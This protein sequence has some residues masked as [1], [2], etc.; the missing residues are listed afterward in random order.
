MFA[1]SKKNEFKL[2]NL[3][4]YKKSELLRNQSKLQI[5]SNKKEDNI[6]LITGKNESVK[7][8]KETNEVLKC[9][10]EKISS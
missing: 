1:S 4:N 3:N 6:K 8:I 5:D 9:K 2:I 10:R 7:S